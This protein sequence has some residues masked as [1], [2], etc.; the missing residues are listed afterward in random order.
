MCLLSFHKRSLITDI[1]SLPEINL[2]SNTRKIS[3]IVHT[4]DYYELIKGK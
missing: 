1:L 2:I 4:Y 3:T